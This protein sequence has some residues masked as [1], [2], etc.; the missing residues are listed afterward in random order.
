MQ[1]YFYKKLIFK[2]IALFVMTL[3]LS[4]CVQ[5]KDILNFRKDAEP[6]PNIPEQYIEN[7]TVLTLQAND[8]LAINVNA[9]DE[10]IAAPFNVVAQNPNSPFIGY[11]INME[12]NINF[13]V[14]GE[15]QVQGLTIDSVRNILIEEIK[16]Y[17][18]EPVVNIRLINFRITVLGEVSK[19]GAFSISSERVTILEALGLAGD[20]TAYSDRDKIM[21]IREE[22]G[23]RIFGRIDLQDENL[24]QSPYYYLKQ[25]DVI[26]VD[27]RTEKTATIR[28]PFTEYLPWISSTLSIITIVIS[29]TTN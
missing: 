1:N 9:F 29:L 12:G 20:L 18:K 7:T 2:T 13:P 26:Y 4:S 19:P 10:K 3:M 14:I 24:F 23:Q 22:D 8:F 15:I 6:L 25:N 16:V 5:Y 11:L 28:D 27:P 17:I 21:V